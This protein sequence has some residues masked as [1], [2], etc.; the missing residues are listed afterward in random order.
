[1][2]IAI[3][4]LICRNI[5]GLQTISKDYTPLSWDFSPLSWGCT[6]EPCCAFTPLSIDWCLVLFMVS[7]IFLLPYLKQRN[8]SN[9]WMISNMNVFI[10]TKSLMW[11]DFY[12]P[13]PTNW[14]LVFVPCF[15]VINNNLVSKLVTKLEV[16]LH[17]FCLE[18][19]PLHCIRVL[20]FVI[21]WYNYSKFWMQ[22]NE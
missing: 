16:F 18:I 13:C 11:I 14:I 3:M 21:G 9:L 17:G 5:T 19:T 2:K 12:L 10:I 4:G 1:M 7:V 15:S 22:Y 8:I 20:I 6:G